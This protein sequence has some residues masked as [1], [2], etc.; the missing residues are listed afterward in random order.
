M[1]DDKKHRHTSLVL[2]FAAVTGVGGTFA[3]TWIGVAWLT[4]L[5]LG[6]LLTS[7]MVIVL[8]RKGAA[9]SNS[10]GLLETPFYLSHDTEIFERY[11]KISQQMLRI[12]QRS[13][14][15]FRDLALQRLDKMAADCTAMGQGQIDLLMGSDGR[16]ELLDFETLPRPVDSPELLHMYE[17]ASRQ[18]WR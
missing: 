12:S 13:S 15:V 14:D 3:V 2:G 18:C 4:T 5:W 7:V 9:G 11:K 1:L 6:I 17:A 8:H 16:L 10:L